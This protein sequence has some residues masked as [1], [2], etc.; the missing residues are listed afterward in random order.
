MKKQRKNWTFDGSCNAIADTMA[1]RM[2]MMNVTQYKSVEPWNL[3]NDI[4]WKCT[5]TEN[6]KPI[7]GNLLRVFKTKTTAHGRKKQQ[8]DL[9]YSLAEVVSLAFGPIPKAPCSALG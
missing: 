2:I 1:K 6:G 3:P 5:S 9:S 8:G 7:V 4:R